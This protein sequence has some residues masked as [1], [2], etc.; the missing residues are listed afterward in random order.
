MYYS[1]PYQNLEIKLKAGMQRLNGKEAEGLVRYLFWLSD[2]DL[3]RIKDAATV[4]KGAYQAKAS[5]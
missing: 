5:G 1:N 4:C 2:A 3:G